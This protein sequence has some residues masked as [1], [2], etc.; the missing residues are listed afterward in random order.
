MVGNSDPTAG[1]LGKA[2][3]VGRHLCELRVRSAKR[4]GG[5]D[6]RECPLD[7][8]QSLLLIEQPRSFRHVTKYK[9]LGIIELHNQIVVGQPVGLV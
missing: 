7:Y 6:L 5:A 2:E 4:I 8:S 3:Q 1:Q 9:I